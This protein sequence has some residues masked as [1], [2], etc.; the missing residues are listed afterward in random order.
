M[1]RQVQIGGGYSNV[2]LPN[3]RAYNAGAT[4]ILTDEEFDRLDPDV[5]GT[6]VIDQGRVASSGD[7]VVTQAA[8]VAA[9][10]ALTSTN[11]AGANPTQAEFNA[12]R[13]DVSALRGTV[14][15]LL[16]ALKGTGKPMAA[17]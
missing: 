9:P 3:G 14:A 11:A 13:A 1:P 10:A 15:D 6:R 8:V 7:A 4:V 2:Q 5:I 12:L 16:T 17:S